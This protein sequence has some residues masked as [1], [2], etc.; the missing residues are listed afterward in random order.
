MQISQDTSSNVEDP[1]PSNLNSINEERA[2]EDNSSQESSN[3]E[4]P[5]DNLQSPSKV[6]IDKDSKNSVINEVKDEPNSNISMNISTD[7]KQESESDDSDNDELELII[8]DIKENLW[9]YQSNNWKLEPNKAKLYSS[10]L[11]NALFEIGKESDSA[12]DSEKIAIKR[13]IRSESRL[14][15]KLQKLC[16]QMENAVRGNM[17]RKRGRPT[18]TYNY[19][20]DN[21]HRK[22][23]DLQL[24]LSYKSEQINKQIL[25]EISL[26]KF[27]KKL[28][29]TNPVI[30]QE[31]P[32]WKTKQLASLSLRERMKQNSEIAK[33]SIITL[34]IMEDEERLRRQRYQQTYNKYWTMRKDALYDNLYDQ[35]KQKEDDSISKFYFA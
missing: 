13:N 29:E 33:R 8:S 25:N 3:E 30:K 35:L 7:I 34:E 28:Q 24:D 31:V 2:L 4:E 27:T 15:E 5:W 14:R 18:Q 16:T 12:K 9:G 32:E 20:I 17:L 1:T 6:F 10:N 19:E 11:Q 22:V 23:W 21:Y 26:S